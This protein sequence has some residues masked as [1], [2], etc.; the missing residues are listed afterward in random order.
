MIVATRNHQYK[1]PNPFQLSSL[2]FHKK[3]TEKP[4]YLK[5]PTHSKNHRPVL[6]LF[7]KAYLAGWISGIA[8]GRSWS[9]SES[10]LQLLCIQGYIVHSPG[11]CVLMK[12]KNKLSKTQNWTKC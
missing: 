11:T 12:T 2:M 5:L 6:L 7:D 3:K 1:L 10:E 4:L 9:L 8:I